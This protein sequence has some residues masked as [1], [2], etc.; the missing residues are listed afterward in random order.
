MGYILPV[1]HYTYQNYHSR[2]VERKKN[3]HYVEAPFKV[4]FHKIDDTYDFNKRKNFH[5]IL[6]EKKKQLEPDLIAEREKTVLTGKGR[7]INQQI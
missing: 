4:R 2:M 7:N 3:P 6:K 1:T 5:T